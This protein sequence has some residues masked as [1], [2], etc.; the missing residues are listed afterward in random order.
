MVFSMH[1]AKSTG[2]ACEEKKEPWS[3]VQVIHSN[4]NSTYMYKVYVYV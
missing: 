3:L 2:Y 4:S 1:S